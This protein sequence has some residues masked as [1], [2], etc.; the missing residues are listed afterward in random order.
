MKPIQWLVLAACCFSTAAFAAH[1]DV[2]AREKQ[3][4]EYK[5]LMGDMG[6]MVKGSQAYD[7]A[8]F[9]Q[10]AAQLHA[11]SS[12]PWRYYSAGA[13]GDA[14]PEVWSKPAEFQAAIK[15]FSDA[16]AALSTAAKAGNLDAIKKPYGDVGQSCKACHD[17]FRR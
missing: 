4:K 17:N 16:S 11:G 10:M 2:A 13:T 14:L 8:A 12:K 7:A 5:K 15:R 9:A 3:M 6:K 1:P